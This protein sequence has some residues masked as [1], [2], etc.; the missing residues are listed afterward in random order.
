VKFGLK[1]GTKM[2]VVG[3]PLAML[4]VLVSSFFAGNY[5]KSALNKAA[6]EKLTAVRELKAQQIEDY[7]ELLANQVVLLAANPETGLKLSAT[8]H[9]LNLLNH[10]IT[11]IL[12]ED[13]QFLVQY[14]K[15][16]VGRQI[17]EK[18]A[19]KISPDQIESLRPTEPMSVL[20]QLQHVIKDPH[21][22]G[23]KY[24]TDVLSGLQSY[25]INISRADA[26][27]SDFAS[28]FGYNDVF[29]ISQ[30]KNRVSYSIKRGI[31]LGTSL[32]DG[33]HA[34]SVLAKITKTAQTMKEGEYAFAD[35]EKY[36]P[37]N[38]TPTAFV[39]TPIF[40]NGDRKGVLALEIPVSKINAMMT[41]NGSWENVGLGK[42]GETYLV[43]NDKLLRNQS[44]FLIEDRVRYLKMIR[45]I[46][47][48]LETVQQIDNL[49]TSIGLQIVDTVGTRAALA[50]KT[51][52]Q[53]FP[54]Y[55]GV[56]VLSA[57][58]PLNLKGLDWVI[59]SEIDE[60]EA[61][62]G[63]NDLR[64]ALIVMASLVLAAAI[65]ASYFLATAF[66][67]PIRELEFAAGQLT[68]GKLNQ[69]IK[70]SSTDEIG[71]LARSIEKMRVALKTS[72]EDVEKQ[73]SELE[74]E[75]V[76]RT[77]EL[78]STSGQLNLALSS[79][80]NGI[81]MLDKDLNF[82]LFNDRYVEMANNPPE[83]V[84]VGK[85]IRGIMQFSAENGYFGVGKVD[86]LV[87]ERLAGLREPTSKTGTFTTISGRMIESK[88]TPLKDG[89]VIVVLSDISDLKEKEQSLE[90]QN[91]D[92]Q[93]MQIDLKMSEQRVA[94]IIQSSPDGIITM[95]KR[96]IIETFSTS[97]EQIF[98]YYSDDI[99]GKN[100]KILLPKSI[101]LEHDFYLEKYVP[102]SPSTIVG[103]KRIVDAV[104]KDGSLFPLEISVEEVWVGDEVI[105]LGLVR[106]ITEMVESQR[107]AK[108][109][110]EALDNFSDMLIL[111][112]KDERV[113][114]TNDCYHEIY[115][116][117]PPKDKIINFTM[118]GL[119]RRSL[120]TG[121][122]TSPLAISDPEVWLQDALANRRSSEERIGETL[123]A[124]GR[125]YMFRHR[126]T[127]EGGLILTQTDITERKRAEAEIM[128]AREEAEK[129][130]TAKSAFLANMSHEL[131]TPMNAIIGYSEML[132]EDAED[133]GLDVML[134][135][136]NKISAAG[137]HLLSLINDVLDLSKIEAGKMDMFLET[138]PVAE[139]TNDVA[140]TSASLIEKNN[141]KL[142]LEVAED[143]GE[144][145]AD[146]TK[147]RQV[148]FNL[149][150][151]AA[152]FT[153][154]GTITLEASRE[155]HDGVSW[156]RFAV[157][158][159]GIGIPEDKL[160]HI[161]E[162]FS[163]ADDTTTK[164]YGGT[165]LGLALTKRFSEM[166]GGSI[167]VESEVGA[168]S[169][170]IITLPA[171]VEKKHEGL[172]AEASIKSEPAQKVALEEL[173]EDV[174]KV[175][176]AEEVDTESESELVKVDKP[177]VLVIDDEKNAR[178]L[179]RR[180]LEGEACHVVT[181]KSG[182]E[183][184]AM[185]AK[186][187]PDL[188]TLDVM[189]PGMDG[190]AVL[191]KLKASADLKD[192]PVVMI[193]MV[194]DK[195]MSFALGAIDAIQKPVDRSKLKSLITKYVNGKSKNVLLV[196]DDEA[197][198]D[199]M[200]KYLESEKW[201]VSE[202]VNGLEGLEEAEKTKFDLVLLDLMMPVMDGF[203][204]L[205]R[206][207]N[208]DLPSSSS[209]VVIVTARDLSAADRARL[210]GNVEEVVMKTG[211]SLDGVID[212]IKGV[213]NTNA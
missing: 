63:F 212:K 45:E 169:S 70:T 21:D 134:A 178:S 123:H 5:S 28:R 56:E 107:A 27:F 188:I 61:F 128:A 159:T 113:V 96:G 106:D 135:D 54:D 121:L 92:L 91:A 189:M 117:S 1:I 100:I 168:G 171:V 174:Q 53:I 125:T 170:F 155:V 165:G 8:S 78:E 114:F 16:V 196:E 187:H 79:M 99:V 30:D 150:S 130:S 180:N 200:R 88:R 89:G 52:T 3:I 33:P 206:L 197:T 139:M 154:E 186:L 64:D 210:Q 190:W 112:D 98:G 47:T 90:T 131:R 151:N 41:S 156:I 108:L 193:S 81:Y 179:L 77:E 183:G 72:F 175:A 19:I 6:F 95:G 122:I 80:A 31:E 82:T 161:F 147:I 177:T 23:Q 162:E 37:A 34:T 127:T 185:A 87:E 83:L 76:A 191:N 158:D 148:L 202:A 94:K 213:L 201:K 140:N 195:N 7:F 68:L 2:L 160:G 42:S 203:E 86:E 138:F 44:R 46:G 133:D 143:A 35:F 118:E 124:N 157:S 211:G 102:G 145:H 194:N 11:E 126:R 13:E 209:P 18:G 71:D 22:Y 75:V 204:F 167:K 199:I 65:Y 198:R 142:E 115:P 144:M 93:K 101:A 137:K 129:A 205:N 184:L 153:K 12:P 69:E 25:Q 111:Y 60:S 105:F 166:M 39:A 26:F 48:D 50:G 119:L 146:M 207:R 152:K 85:S 163:Q 58:K 59:M 164:E 136:L 40:V 55:R 17:A 132:A 10:R 57:Y 116:D 84:A 43:G 74:T 38:G 182:R 103:K 104:R 49:N 36:L 110:R 66:T 141:N 192:I 15:D 176:V 29:L 149:I 20:V 109:L 67:R 97:A 73:K 32:V 14:Y 173:E 4:I 172:E 51:G 9:I 208:S 62:A 120:E 181:A 24:S